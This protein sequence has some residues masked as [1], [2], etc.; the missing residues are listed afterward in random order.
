WELEFADT[1]AV[2]PYPKGIAVISR[3]GQESFIPIF[4]A[5]EL[6]WFSG[7]MEERIQQYNSGLK[8]AD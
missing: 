2:T 4:Q 3:S 6:Q 1:A 8:A 5:S 7:K